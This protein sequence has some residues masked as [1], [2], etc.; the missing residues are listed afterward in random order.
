MVTRT[1]SSDDNMGSRFHV[2]AEAL[3]RC[4]FTLPAQV[5]AMRTPLANEREGRGRRGGI[6]EGAAR[7]KVDHDKGGRRITRTDRYDS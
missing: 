1:W 3:T 7:S 2:R 6:E 4:H 5:N